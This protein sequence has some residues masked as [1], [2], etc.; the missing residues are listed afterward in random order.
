[1]RKRRVLFVLLLMVGFITGCQRPRVAPHYDRPLP[2][3]ELA[4][5]KITNPREIPDFTDGCYSMAR[6][7]TA[8]D[9]S[10]NY[11]N[12][13]SSQQFFPYGEIT[14][15]RAVDSLK[16]FKN[17]I[18]SGLRGR[19]LNDAIAEEFDVYVSVGC[20]DMGT[21]LFTGYYTPI[22]DGSAS[23]TVQFKYPLYK[24]PD[25]LV[26]DSQGHILG[27]RGPDGRIAPYPSRAEIESSGMLKGDE[28]VW[29]GDSFEAYIAHVQGSAKLRMPDGDLVTVGYAASNGHEY[30]SVAQELI[31]DGKIAADKLSLSTMIDYFKGNM[32]QVGAYTRRNPRFVFFRMENGPPRGS[33]NEPVTLMRTIATDKSIYP[34]ACL[35][36]ISTNLP[37]LIGGTIYRDPYK[38]FVLDQDTGGAIRAPGRCDV[39]MG[40]GDNAGQLAGQTYQEGRL[41]YLFLKRTA[42]PSLSNLPP[43]R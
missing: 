8:I 18:D 9:N 26:K 42:L 28:L 29:L 23:A 3:G 12:K 41:Y 2:P 40:E 17:L 31:R 7:Q 5:R 19:E 13:P 6:M 34:R 22:F 43:S 27:R 30:Q 11:L 39:Y 32:D 15:Q 1:M 20:D 16:A 25:D 36:F 33:L 4:L 24:Q 21:V 14:H 38:G 35:A 37:R 10:L